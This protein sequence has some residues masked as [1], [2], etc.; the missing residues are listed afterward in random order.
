M[1]NFAK[2]K[3]IKNQKSDFLF[4]SR[5][6]DNTAKNKHFQVSFA[7]KLNEFL[8][9]VFICRLF[10]FGFLGLYRVSPFGIGALFFIYLHQHCTFYKKA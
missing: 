10:S 2:E 3:K 8:K 4:L 5:Q 6:N 1:R 9:R 7:T